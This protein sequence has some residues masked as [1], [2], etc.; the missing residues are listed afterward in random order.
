MKIH[1]FKQLIDPH[2]HFRFPGQ[3]NKETWA[4][5][6]A[7][8]VAGGLTIVLD[9]PNNQPPTLTEKLLEE[10][11]ENARQNSLVNFGFHFGCSANNL[12]EIARLKNKI[13]SVKVFMNEITGNLLIKDDK[14][15]EKIFSL[16]DLVC[17]YAEREMIEKAVWLTEKCKNKL[18]FCHISEK[19]EIDYLK[20][21]KK[22]LKIYIE[23]TPHHL[24]LTEEDN[25]NALTKMKPSLKKKKDQAALW[26]AIDEGIVDTI[27]TDHAPH[28]LE[29]KKDDDPPSGVPGVETVLP[30]LLDAYHQGKISLEGIER[31]MSENPAEI[32]RIQRQE[33]TYTLVDL[34]SE[35]EVKKENLRSKCGWSPFVGWRLKGWPIKTV[36]NGK[37]VF[38]K[39]KIFNHN[40]DH[41]IYGT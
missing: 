32:F 24:F 15:L 19:K 35:K 16:V 26:Q 18:Y 8:A 5:G 9:M 33:D 41:Y 38:E 31:L 22:K 27:G 28:T 21:I 23:V 12:E 6:S 40:L 4:A 39:D 13:H 34:D 37:I 36:I 7:A 14:I 3:E 10:K 20:K 25:K 11:I 17:V 1:K 2:V 29:E 30:L